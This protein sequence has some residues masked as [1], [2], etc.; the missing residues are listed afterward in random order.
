LG[1]GALKYFLLKVDPKKR[2]LFDPQESIEFQGH[3]GPFIQYT[4]AR[5]SAILRRADGLGV[6]QD[7][8]PASITSLHPRELE[9]VSKL[10]E[11]PSTIKIS[12]E[13]YSPAVVA[14]YVYEVAK[15]YNGFYQDVQI[16]N[17]DDAEKLKMRI[18]LSAAVANVINKGMAL[19]G[20]NVPERM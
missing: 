14:N 19:L 20:V 5:I 9:I 8:S 3:T 12:A 10:V 4:H 16:F 17:E 6:V 1:L 18:T 15:T 7:F 11:F 2:M 13:E